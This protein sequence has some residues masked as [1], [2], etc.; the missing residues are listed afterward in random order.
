M[1]NILKNKFNI[2]DKIYDICTEVEKEIH[3]HIK[4]IEKVEQINQCKVLKAFSNNRISEVHFTGTTGYGYDD[5]GREALDSVY[6]EV[7]GAEDALVRHSIVSGTHALSLCLFG[8]LRPGDE[9]LAVTGSPYDT[10]E[11]IIGIRGG[12]G[13]TTLKDMGVSYNQTNVLTDNVLNCEIIKDYITYNTKLV[14]I[15]RSRGYEWRKS[16][17]INDIKTV[18]ETVKGINYDLVC[19]VDN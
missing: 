2:C 14:Y 3:E 1:Q 13:R 5:M 12:P 17:S 15:Q 6:A 18:I 11:E 16:L 7:L 19:L 8:I 4:D 10:L 9:M